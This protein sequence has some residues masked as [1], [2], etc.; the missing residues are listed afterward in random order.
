EVDGHPCVRLR[1]LPAADV[2][3]DYIWLSLEHYQ[4]VKL[5]SRE[6][7]GA[8]GS[9]DR[10]RSVLFDQ[11]EQVDGVWF[12]LRSRFYSDDRLTRT[13]RIEDVRTNVGI[14]DSYFRLD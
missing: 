4:E 3:H 13:L 14:Y 2:V 6:E 5:M 9:D 12:A 7:P 11:F 1:V 10:E 8:D